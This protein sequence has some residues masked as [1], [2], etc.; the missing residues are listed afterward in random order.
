[1]TALLVLGSNS[2]SGASFCAYALDHGF[3][4]IATSRS[5]EESEA[6][7]PYK[8]RERKG[9]TFYQV[10]LNHDME[11]LRVLIYRHRPKYVLNFA[12]QAMVAQSWEHPTHWMQTNVVSLTALLEVLKGVDFL[13]RYIHFTTPEVY[14]STPNWLTENRNYRPSTPYALSRAAGDMCVGLWTETYGLPAILTRVGSLYGEGQRVYRI[15]PRTFLCCFTG[16]KLALEGGGASERCFVHFDD[17]SRAL[18][19]ICSRGENGSDYHIS[20][21]KSTSIRELV[22]KVCAIAKVEFDEIAYMAKDRRG[23]DQAY[24]LDSSKIRAELGWEP[25]ISLD[26]GLE[27]CGAWCSKYLK[28]LRELPPAY[29]H[30]P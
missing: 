13:D 12:A 27:R 20:S 21:P 25:K 23:K 5:P 15:V 17:V 22:N 11:A 19:L 18:L 9:L 24:L 30:K 8:W 3:E 4:V 14:G 1:M 10:D 26:E 16:Q 6:F 28:T 29:Q 7:L 2:P